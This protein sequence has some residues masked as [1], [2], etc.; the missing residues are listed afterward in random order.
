MQLVMFPGICKVFTCISLW[1]ALQ[2][3]SAPKT[4]LEVTLHGSMRMKNR[5]LWPSQLADLNSIKD[6]WKFLEFSDKWLVSSTA[7]ETPTEGRFL[8]IFQYMSLC[9][10]SR[11][12]YLVKF[13]TLRV[14]NCPHISFCSSP[15]QA[16]YN[17]SL[18]FNFFV[19]FSFFLDT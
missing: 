15:T 3:D 12:F 14:K 13:S 18:L 1:Q 2:D 9:Y 16:P 5:M 6:E 8:C 17:L 19:Y 4:R 10:S 7:I 11:A